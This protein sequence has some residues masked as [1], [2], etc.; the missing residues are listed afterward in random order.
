MGLG[1]REGCRALVGVGIQV[2]LPITAYAFL[3]SYEANWG[4]FWIQQFSLQV[5]DW[6]GIV[7]SIWILLPLISPL[8]L[9]HFRFGLAEW[10]R[11]S[12]S[13]GNGQPMRVRVA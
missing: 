6:V 13:Y 5:I 3:L 1:L 12:M 8:W 11:R 4:N 7:V 10:L 2:G 9:K